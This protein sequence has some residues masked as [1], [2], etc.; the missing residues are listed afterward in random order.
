[1]KAYT[2]PVMTIMAV[3]NEVVLAASQNT[4]TTPG[5]NNVVSNQ[6]AM[7]KKQVWIEEN[8]VSE[9]YPEAGGWEE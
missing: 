3:E 8:W 2:K 6:A 4:P 1:M 9:E 7:S 5:V